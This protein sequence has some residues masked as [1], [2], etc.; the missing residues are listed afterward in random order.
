M[1]AVLRAEWES[2]DRVPVKS[3]NIAS[4]AYGGPVSRLFV[5]FKSGNVY[6]Y[7]GVP[8]GIFDALQVAPSVGAAFYVLVRNKGKDDVFAYRQV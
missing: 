8:R 6:A 4:V 3:S 1:S 2:L 7:D 5:E